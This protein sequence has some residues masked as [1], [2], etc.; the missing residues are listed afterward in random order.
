MAKYNKT[1]VKRIID[2]IGHDNYTVEELCSLSGIDEATYY[3][4]LKGKSEFREAVTR[5]RSKHD[6]LLVKE[7]KNSLI[8]KV[9]G[10]TVQ[11]TKT[12]MVDSGKPGPHGKPTPK[13]KERIV[14]ERHIQP[15]TQTI[16]FVLTNKAPDE[17]KNRQSTELTGKN[18]K[19]L[20][21]ARILTMK[22]AR[23]F[24]EKL[25]SEI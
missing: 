16:M 10:Y 9:K 12:V 5:A 21:P 14:I 7:A 19:E 6:E 23:K 22:E 20:L 13:I 11:E 18:G 3:R 17:Y 15:D 1:V 25:T 8:K 4:W 2:L 24:M